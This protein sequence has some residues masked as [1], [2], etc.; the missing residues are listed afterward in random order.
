MV[1]RWDVLHSE[2]A[3]DF[4]YFRVR[5]D[6]ARH[7]ERG[8]SHDFYLLDMPDIVHVVAVTEDSELVLVRQ[9][10]HA[11]REVTLEVPAGHVEPGEDPALAGARELR[12][13]T[14]YEAA[15]V[16]P[17]GAMRPSPAR[18]MNR[19]YFYL[20]TGL[21]PADR[22]HSDA[23][24]ETDVVRVPVEDIPRLIEERQVIDTQTAC[25]FFLYRLHVEAGARLAR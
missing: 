8:D 21:R 1:R 4:R 24:E 3:A 18:M 9:Y 17:L 7:P 10:R 2:Q 11:A 19:C 12:E 23:V 14:G 25:A 22:A 5:R 16:V 20:A 15:S 13:E 6:S